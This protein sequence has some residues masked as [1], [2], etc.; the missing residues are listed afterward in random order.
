MLQLQYS[1]TF[2]PVNKSNRINKAF[3][4]SDLGASSCDFVKFFNSSIMTLRDVALL[5]YTNVLPIYLMLIEHKY[6]EVNEQESGIL[7]VNSI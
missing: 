1:N 3:K 4:M 2:S 6:L 7:V 5:S